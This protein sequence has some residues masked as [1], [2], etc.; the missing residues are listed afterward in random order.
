MGS[1][2][3]YGLGS[4]SQNLPGFV[5]LTSGVGTSAGS[6]N[7]SSGFLP[8]TYAGTVFRS[9]GD[10]ILYLS[11]PAGI[12]DEAQR[13]RLDL[14]RETNAEHQAKTGDLEIA[15][16][17]HSY[18]MAYKLQTAG[19]ELLDFSKESAATR[20]PYGV[21][22]GGHASRSDK[23][24]AGAEDGGARGSVRHADARQL[25]PPQRNRAGLKKHCG[26]TDQPD[27]GAGEGSEAAR[28]AR[29]HAG[30]LGRRIRPD[31][32]VGDAKSR[33]SEQHRPRPSSATATACG[34]R[35]AGSKAV[36]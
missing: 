34:W 30:G 3:N 13:M 8:S 20:E 17:I 28:H 18:E 23:L 15:S 29:R 22:Q 7:F 25:G 4:E 32:D 19:P 36:R 12:T 6:D 1:W 33:R 21:E 10:P 26:A 24:P 16:R 35:A 27:G 31:A 14:I 9:Q 11:N 2:I 5:V